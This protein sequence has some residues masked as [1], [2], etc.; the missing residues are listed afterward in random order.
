[1][2]IEF[3]C[4]VCSKRFKV[5]DKHVG[6]KTSCR[7]CGAA[8][9]I[10]DQGEAELSGDT[11][12]GSTLYDH[13]NKE[14]R[15]LGIS[16]GDE[17][18][19]EAVSE[20]I[21][22]H[23]GK[24]D[25]VFHEL[26]S[27]GVHVD[28]HVINPTTERP[29]YTLVTSGMSELPMTTPPGAEELAY[30]ELVL[31]LPPDWKMSQDA[32]E[33]ESNYWPIRWMKILAR[34]P[35]DYETFFTISHTIPGGNPPEEFDAS[36]PMGCW[37]FVA[38]FMFEEESFELQHDGHTVNFLYMLPLHLDE[39]EFKLKHGF[40]EAVDRIMESFE[41]R[42]LIDMQRPSFM[43]LDWAPARR[44]KR[45]SIVASCPCGETF[46]AKT[47]DAGK[48]I[49]CPK[50]SQPVYVPCSTLAVTG[51]YPDG[52]AASNPA[53][54][55]LKL[56]RYVSLR[57]IEILWWG[58]PAV[59]FVLLGIMVHWS[60]FIPAV[61]LFGIFA[62]RWRKL[63]HH[64]K[65][66]DSRPGVIV[67]LDPPLFASITDLDLGA[68]GGERLAVKV[69][70]FFSKQID[71]SPIKIGERI[72]TAAAYHEDSEKGDKATSWGDFEPIPVA[73]ANGDPAAARYVISQIDDEEWKQLSEGLKQVPRPL[74]PGLYDVTL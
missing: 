62:L 41:I 48:S 33:D 14:R 40:D 13:S 23:F 74:K 72:P 68:G 10:P 27:T 71:G 45:Q 16:I 24:V 29:Y 37:M 46:E 73:Y 32:F 8:I 2:P 34:F 59:L 25:N 12:G 69:V 22:K 57:P 9:T 42:E 4:P 38:P 51:N 65:D 49:P 17:G 35:H 56:G 6:R 21:E 1:M 7:S 55:S 30:A 52:P 64:F 36:T 20:H 54:V 63:H 53:G 47:G 31:C 44:S 58:I 70:P 5:D 26:I 18:L 19:I 66:G 50:C 15:D 67:S 28:V 61:I 60:L 39:M 43:Q 11:T 3:A